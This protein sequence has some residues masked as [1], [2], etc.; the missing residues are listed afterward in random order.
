MFVM[1]SSVEDQPNL[2][3]YLDNEEEIFITSHVEFLYNQ[4][5]YD[6]LVFD[7]YPDDEDDI[8]TLTSIDL[9]SNESNFSK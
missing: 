5:I 6:Q 8:F 2:D 9:R 4:P 1:I 3:G 7:N